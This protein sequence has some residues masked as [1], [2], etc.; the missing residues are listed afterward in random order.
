LRLPRDKDTILEVVL[1]SGEAERLAWLRRRHGEAEISRW[2]PQA[3]GNV[4]TL[5]RILRD[6]IWTLMSRSAP[7][8]SLG[9]MYRLPAF[10]VALLWC[11]APVLAVLH[12]HSGTEVHRYCAE[13]GTL[14]DVAEGQVQAQAPAPDG[15]S[16]T[17]RASEAQAAHRGCAFAPFC[18]FGDT[19]SRFQFEA[20]G[21]LAATHVPAPA[22]R[23]A[24]ASIPVFVLAPK[25]SPPL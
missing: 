5:T 8:P 14:E 9:A 17:V 16:P 4:L 18:R 12:G 22:A 11:A 25:T 3:I 23:L 13:H 19:L 7:L 10:T 21:V 1:L 2:I 20:T 15:N 24:P 6:S